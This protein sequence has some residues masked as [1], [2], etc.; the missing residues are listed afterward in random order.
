MPKILL[1]QSKPVGGN[2][3]TPSFYVPADLDGRA[4]ELF[5]E[6]VDLFNQMEFE[7]A[8]SKFKEAI[9]LK[10]D[11]YYLKCWLYYTFTTQNKD[12]D[13]IL[14]FLAQIDDQKDNDCN[15]M[16]L[17]LMK[18]GYG[19]I[20]ELKTILKKQPNNFLLIS[21]IATSHFI[22]K[23]WNPA[24]EYFEKAIKLNKKCK[25]L[26]LLLIEVYLNTGD[27][28]KAIQ[29]YERA[30]EVFGEGLYWPS[31]IF[32]EYGH[33]MLIKGD[34]DTALREFKKAEMTSND[35]SSK[36][37]SY[38]KYK[39]YSS[40]GL[41]MLMKDSS[42]SA[43][44]YYQKAID[45]YEK[46]HPEN[47]SPKEVSLFY[48]I[49]ASIYLENRNFSNALKAIES[50]IDIDPR[51]D[52]AIYSWQGAIHNR[53]GQYSEAIKELE[54]ALT[55]PF[56]DKHENLAAKLILANTYA[57]YSISLDNDNESKKFWKLSTQLLKKIENDLQKDAGAHYAVAVCYLDLKLYED[58]LRLLKKVIKLDP[59]NKLVWEEVSE[60]IEIFLE[61]VYFHYQNG[62][63]DL[64]YDKF[65]EC[66]QHVKQ[67]LLMR[68]NDPEAYALTAR[69]LA[70]I[71]Q[72][73]E[74]KPYYEKAIQMG[75]ANS[76]SLSTITFFYYISTLTI[77]LEIDKAVGYLKK[78]EKNQS[79]DAAHFVALAE[80]Y[81]MLADFKERSFFDKSVAFADMALSISPDSNDA[82]KVKAYAL[83]RLGK[84][85]EGLNILEPIYHAS[86]EL[87]F[88]RAII[89]KESG[90]FEESLAE[91]RAVKI[92]SVIKYHV[93]L[94][95]A[96]CLL[97]LGK[98][99]EAK[100]VIDAAILESPDIGFFHYMNAHILEDNKDGDKE[101]IIKGYEKALELSPYIPQIYLAYA[102]FL[103]DKKDYK[104]AKEIL[105]QLT[106][107]APS[108]EDAISTKE[109]I[110]LISNEPDESK[111]EDSRGKMKMVESV[112]SPFTPSLNNGPSALGN[113][114]VE[115]R[116][117]SELRTKIKTLK[118]QIEDQ[119]NIIY[120]YIKLGGLYIDLEM[121][122]EATKVL[123][124]GLTIDGK[125]RE[126]IELKDVA[127]LRSEESMQELLKTLPL[128]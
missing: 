24:I 73:E 106:K 122:A 63:K 29:A 96:D 17:L 120:L 77:T 26:H 71:G 56:R 44:T 47:V 76:S 66:K 36:Y 81:L 87:R 67:M 111:R 110:E 53:Q 113:N 101:A 107:I 80:L 62:A 18:K 1:A 127:E 55:L 50:S 104:R 84:P 14:D 88:E 75:I 93:T 117:I 6:G 11:S 5:W 124:K 34:I 58:A 92:S 57:K 97:R 118:K 126:L 103:S 22:L 33:E 59:N 119:P 43:L 48:A 60:I 100:K 102:L 109:L 95:I 85:L 10:P 13:F 37:S 51:L 30:L 21:Q 83:V 79:K 40:L 27:R 82:L 49:I 8:E 90:K 41:V 91:L 52:G 99:E 28:K 20:A 61:Q 70:Y 125:N 46:E 25:F 19:T 112:I 42:N 86:D 121:F 105:D 4:K 116:S 72:W 3:D 38:S 15:H 31:L 45:I 89:L 115:E 7:K 2:I 12:D 114:A 54:T 16:L 98:K 23:D 65:N 108:N 74:S 39:T 35:D 64:A 68:P 9:A 123:E 32:I 94:N 128:K 78:M 69:V